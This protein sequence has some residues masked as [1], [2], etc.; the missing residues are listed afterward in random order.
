MIFKRKAYDKLLKWKEECDGSRAIMIEGARRIGKSTLVEEFAKNEYDSYLMID[1]SKVNDTIKSYFYDY[2]EDLDTLFMFITSAYNVKLHRRKSVIIFDEVQRFPRARECIKHLVADGRYDYIE[3][4]SLISI[5]ENVKD[6]LIPSEE[7]SLKMYPISDGSKCNPAVLY[8]DIARAPASK[9]S[10]FVLKPA[11]E[12]CFL[13]P[14]TR[15]ASNLYSQLGFLSG[16][17]LFLSLTLIFA[18]VI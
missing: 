7:R 4:G 3:T 9:A 8:S 16:L 10:F 15:A 13:L 6:I 17:F 11:L 5:R 2:I 18:I 14:S 1:F 12:M